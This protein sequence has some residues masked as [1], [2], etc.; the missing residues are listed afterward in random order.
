MTFSVQVRI[1]LEVSDLHTQPRVSLQV[2]FFSSSIFKILLKVYSKWLICPKS[3]SCP[4]VLNVLLMPNAVFKLVMHVIVTIIQCLFSRW[5]HK[6]L[7]IVL[8][9]WGLITYWPRKDLNPCLPV[10]SMLFTNGLSFFSLHY[11]V[12][13]LYLSLKAE[14]QCYFP[15][16]TCLEVC[17][18]KISY[19]TYH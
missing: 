18:F 4:Q 7:D 9:H 19:I 5:E 14:L 15:H 13:K 10:S 2:F 1:P 12:S 16:E 8:I 11:Y 6:P 3:N 17:H